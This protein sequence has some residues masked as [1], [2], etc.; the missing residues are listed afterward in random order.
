MAQKVSAGLL[1]YKHPQALQVCLGHPGGPYFRKKDQHAWTIPKG[2]VEAEE[3]LLQAAIREFQEETNI[4]P[5]PPFLPLEMVKYSKGK[6]L[7][8][9]AFEGQ[10]KIED[11]F[12]SNTFTIEW[13]PKTG[14]R[15]SFPELDALHW[16]SLSEAEEKI[17]PVQWT[18]VKQ[19]IGW[20]SN[21]TP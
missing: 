4:I 16:F 2:L 21:L 17:H 6:L 9:W 7:H 8:A 3:P 15:Q 20:V 10:W 11:G 13:P 19:L 14:K 1:M 18:L 5:T 12:K